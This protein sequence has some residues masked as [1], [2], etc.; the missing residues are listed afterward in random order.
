[1]RPRVWRMLLLAQL[2]E[3]PLRIAVTVFAIALGVALG[4]AVYLVNAGALNEFGLAAKRLVG[5]ADVIVRG[6]REGFPDSLY[7]QLARDPAVAAASPVLETEAA[8]PGRRDTLKVLGLDVFRATALQPALFG[9][10][11][12]RVLDLFHAD[13]IF[14]SASAAEQL[15]VQPRRYPDPDCRQLSQI[16]ACA[17]HPVRGDLSAAS[18]HHGHCLR[19][20]GLRPGGPLESHRCALEDRHIG[21]GFSQRTHPPLTRRRIRR[22]AERRA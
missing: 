16:A 19:A 22:G 4:V 12:G 17:R 21:G 18:R 6:P 10:I 3:Q 7:V 14:L 11:G 9:D 2:R 15:K 13:G 8:L 20:M 5:E 1:V